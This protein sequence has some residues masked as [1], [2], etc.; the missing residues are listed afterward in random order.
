MPS[1]TSSETGQTVIPSLTIMT[2]T[3]MVTVDMAT[4]TKSDLFPVFF[5]LSYTVW[6]SAIQ[7]LCTWEARRC[8]SSS[9]PYFKLG[10]LSILTANTSLTGGIEGFLL[11][12]TLVFSYSVVSW[13]TVIQTIVDAQVSMLMHVTRCAQ[14]LEWPS[15]EGN[16]IEKTL[17]THS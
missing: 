5:N 1:K 12:Y 4:V 3:D 9:F 13:M 7:F 2:M 16:G 14:T 10:I 15:N 17:T 6:T 8:R 11:C